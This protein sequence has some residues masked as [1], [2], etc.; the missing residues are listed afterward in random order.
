[1]RV[2]CSLLARLC[3]PGSFHTVA[4]AEELITVSQKQKARV[5]GEAEQSSGHTA[6]TV[7]IIVE[8]LRKQDLSVLDGGW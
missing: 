6:D 5:Y 2:W 4:V 3:N 8:L 7:L 1:M